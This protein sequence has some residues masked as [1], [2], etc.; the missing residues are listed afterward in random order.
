MAK[1]PNDQIAK[2]PNQS[3]GKAVTASHSFGHLVIWQFGT[4]LLPRSLSQLLAGRSGFGLTCTTLGVLALLPWTGWATGLHYPVE[5]VL[6]PAQSVIRSTW[7][8]L[9]GA[10]RSDVSNSPEL[11]AVRLKAEE[12]Q[13]RYLAAVKEIDLLREEIR[14]LARLRELDPQVEDRPIM[15]S[16]I[17][18]AADLGAGVWTLKA[19]TIHGVENGAIVVVRGVHLVGRINSVAERS[20]TVKPVI[21]RGKGETTVL[22]G[23]VM[24][25]ENRPGPACNL[26]VMGDGTFKGNVSTEG[27]D[28]NALTSELGR[29]MVVRL[30]DDSWPRTARMLVLGRIEN[31][32]Q[33]P[34][35]M[36]RQ[37]ITV[38]PVYTLDR[39]T[40]VMIRT[41]SAL[42]PVSPTTAS[43]P[44]PTM[45]GAATTPASRKG[46]TTP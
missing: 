44:A 32:E 18:P 42:V 17:G 5:A 1:L 2:G 7:V 39:F 43:T 45:P 41:P 24:L 25:D 31:I 13:T 9:L 46:G 3:T 4:L 15:A 28:P 34:E 38:K 36:R 27:L 40:S 26:T 21:V 30:A 11:E 22:R 33:S 20:S 8:S 6:A 14:G 29:G 16:V 35:Q 23:V 19:G 10:S 37:I 12:A